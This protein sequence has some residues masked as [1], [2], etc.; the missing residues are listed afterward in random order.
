VR[1]SCGEF[2]RRSHGRFP[3][4]YVTRRTQ[5]EERGVARKT[6]TREEGRTEV[7]AEEKKP[8]PPPIIDSENGRK[9]KDSDIRHLLDI[10]Q[11]Q[12]K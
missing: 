9:L 12:K 11:G 2:T 7:S 6:R 8:P 10:V 1:Q 4:K 5:E 3:R